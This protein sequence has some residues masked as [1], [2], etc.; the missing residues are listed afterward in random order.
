MEI[1]S[2]EVEEENNITEPFAETPVTDMLEEPEEDSKNL[3]TFEKQQINMKRRIEALEQ[4]NIGEK[5]WALKGEVSSKARPMNSLLEEDFEIEQAS[6]PAPVIDETSTQTMDEMIIQRIKDRAWDDVERKAHPKN[7]QFDPNHRY[8]LNDQKSSK[9]LAQI[10]EEEFTKVNQPK[11]STEKEVALLKQHDEIDSLMKSLFTNLDALSNYH[12]APR[13]ATMELTVIPQASIPA[14][15]LEEVIPA[16]VSN[17]MLAAP[18]EVYDVK[19]GKTQEEMDS[20][21]KK[22]ARVLAKRI[23][24]TDR[25]RREKARELSD[26]SKSKSNSEG[27]IMSEHSA[28]KKLMKH[29]N[30]TFIAK[31][32]KDR[33]SLKKA[34]NKSKGTKANVIDKGGKVIKERTQSRPEMLKL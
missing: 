19:V 17:A 25:K 7:T 4:E 10:Y 21:D 1:D 8:E 34:S 3:S 20:N 18:K 15:S 23:I 29:D 5:K 24:S 16:N 22:K 26:K 33:N 27:I 14:I 6:K 13:D 9:S 32:S 28:V 30:V 31:D 2:P 12:F 11:M